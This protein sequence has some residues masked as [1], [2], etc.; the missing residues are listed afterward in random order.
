MNWDIKY[1]E[2]A[3]S[4]DRVELWRAMIL[5]VIHHLILKKNSCHNRLSKNYVLFKFT[6]DFDIKRTFSAKTNIVGKK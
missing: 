2:F 4:W 6:E 1:R 3:M 5:K